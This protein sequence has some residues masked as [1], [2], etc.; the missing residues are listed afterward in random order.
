MVIRNF[1]E[2]IHLLL[3]KIFCIMYRNAKKFL[4][5]LFPLLFFFLF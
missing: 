2:S 4:P 3:K 5:Q 1:T